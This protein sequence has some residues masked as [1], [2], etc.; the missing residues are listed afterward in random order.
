MFVYE[1]YYN[2]IKNKYGSKVRLLFTDTDRLI[3]EIKTK[4]IYDDFN[5]DKKLFNNYSDK[6]KKNF[7]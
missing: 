2:C 3:S 6:S 4:D 7:S 5:K 1:F